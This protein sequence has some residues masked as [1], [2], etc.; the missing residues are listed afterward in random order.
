M[1]KK[2]RQLSNEQVILFTDWLRRNKADMEGNRADAEKVATLASNELG[3]AIVVSTVENL[4]PTIGVRVHPVTE[5]AK[6]THRIKIVAQAVL[7][8]YERLGEP[9]PTSLTRVAGSRTATSSSSN[10]SS[11]LGQTDG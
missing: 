3:F 4:A 6:R 8:L 11:R 2:R 1:T 7:N 10:G 9:V 5:K